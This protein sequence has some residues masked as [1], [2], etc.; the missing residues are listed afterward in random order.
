MQQGARAE[1]LAVIRFTG[2]KTPE[3]PQHSTSDMKE[4]GG[5]VK[6]VEEGVNSNANL[7]VNE[8]IV[9]GVTC[10]GRFMMHFSSL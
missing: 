2:H 8:T 5:L 3:L 10:L 1:I 6:T 9:A 7:G 4:G